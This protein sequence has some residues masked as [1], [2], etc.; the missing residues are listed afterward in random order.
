M[1]SKKIERFLRILCYFWNNIIF[2]YKYNLGKTKCHF[3][4]DNASDAI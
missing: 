2:L 1:N 4:F 3:F